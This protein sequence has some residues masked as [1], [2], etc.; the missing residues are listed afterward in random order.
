MT[1][2]ERSRV[3]VIG[4]VLTLA[5]L[6]GASCEAEQDKTCAEKTCPHPNETPKRVKT[7]EGYRCACGV[8][9]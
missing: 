4:V 7:S 1:G 8:F 6:I 3:Y 9:L 5:F 2:A